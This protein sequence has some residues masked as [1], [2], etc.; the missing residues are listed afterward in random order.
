MPAKD[1]RTPATRKLDSAELLLGILADPAN[2]EAL[3]RLV[4][5][6]RRE[7]AA[8]QAAEAARPALRVIEGGA[9]PPR[10]IPWLSEAE[11]LRV[12][13]LAAPVTLRLVPDDH[14]TTAEQT[15]GRNER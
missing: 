14:T 10:G 13:V 11:Q 9:E 3:R 6:L 4:D 1:H 2:T 12:G 7:Q 8:E 5:D 15:T